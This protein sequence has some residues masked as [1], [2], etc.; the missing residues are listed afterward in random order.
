M[1]K[2]FAKAP[3]L[4][5]LLSI[6]K[7]GLSWRGANAADCVARLLC[8]FIGNP[9]GA[10]YVVSQGKYLRRKEPCRDATHAYPPPL[11]THLP[12]EAEDPETVVRH[13]EPNP[14]AAWPA[15]IPTR[16][17]SRGDGLELQT[18]SNGPRRPIAHMAD[19][20]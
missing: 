11:S 16:A 9:Y 19:K 7:A 12:P 5:G 1:A 8:T 6:G 18:T 13:E 17:M 20:P 4:A 2:G 3:S 14:P 15:G 10:E